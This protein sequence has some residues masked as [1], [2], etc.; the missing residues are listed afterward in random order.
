MSCC[1]P[2]IGTTPRAVVWLASTAAASDAAWARAQAGLLDPSETQRL[3]R[4]R[5]G[6]RRAQF[7]AAHAAVRQ[8]AAARLGL[9]VP[10]INIEVEPD[11]RPVLRGVELDISLSHSADRVAAAASQSAI[12]VDIER[13]QPARGADSVEPWA[14]A[15]ARW[16]AGDSSAPA[17]VTRTDG[18]VLA[19]AGCTDAPAAYWYD[20]LA[21]TGAAQPMQLAWRHVTG[22]PQ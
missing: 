16:K 14:V 11:G 10:A 4:I 2:S 3:A 17:W 8:L 18:F 19:V 5:R 7:V 13:L 6:A 12:G 15:E 9:P 20:L 1:P 21:P 22:A